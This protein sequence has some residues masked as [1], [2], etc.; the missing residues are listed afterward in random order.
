MLVS[1]NYKIIAVNL[2]KFYNQK[3]PKYNKLRNAIK[4]KKIKNVKIINIK[5]YNLKYYVVCLTENGNK[6]STGNMVYNKF[7]L[8]KYFNLVL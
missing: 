4:N 8:L 6:S 3:I 2:W 5:I 1:H 7:K